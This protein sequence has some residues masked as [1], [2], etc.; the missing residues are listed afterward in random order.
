LADSDHERKDINTRALI[1]RVKADF[2]SSTREIINELAQLRN[3]VGKVDVGLQLVNGEMKHMTTNGRLLGILGAAAVVIVGAAWTVMTVTQKA[4]AEDNRE[5]RADV[6]SRV[7]NAV[8]RLDDA[9][10]ELWNHRREDD[11]K[12]RKGKE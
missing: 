10:R 8:L 3:E 5:I 6:S 11:A 7:N 1:D 2:H 9:Q 12:A 4:I